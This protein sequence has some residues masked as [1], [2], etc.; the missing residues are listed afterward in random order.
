MGGSIVYFECQ[1]MCVSA[2]VWVSVWV[3]VC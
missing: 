1:W 3:Y 2:C